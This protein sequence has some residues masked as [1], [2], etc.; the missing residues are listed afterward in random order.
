MIIR[1]L[2]STAALLVSLYWAASI[3]SATEPCEKVAVIAAPVRLAFQ[4]LRA[5]DAHARL[6][7]DSITWLEWQLRADHA[8]QGVVSRVL[9]GKVECAGESDVVR[10]N[11]LGDVRDGT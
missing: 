4:G 8:A 2:V 7:T 9:Y 5:A 6:V 1:T 10:L 11:R 3:L